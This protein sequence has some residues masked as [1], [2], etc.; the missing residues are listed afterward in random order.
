MQGLGI[1]CEGGIFGSKD[2]GKGYFLSFLTIELCSTGR[3][4]AGRLGGFGYSGI[5]GFMV[6]HLV[7]E[8]FCS[9]VKSGFFGPI[10]LFRYG[11]W[12][13]LLPHPVGFWTTAHKMFYYSCLL[14]VD[15]KAHE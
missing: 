1:H 5:L 4:P 8:L 3:S 11:D 10:S 2:G 7:V 15:Q 14:I 6:F 13:A 9:G 12:F